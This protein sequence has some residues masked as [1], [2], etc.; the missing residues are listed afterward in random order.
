MLSVSEAIEVIKSK[1]SLIGCETIFV[2]KALGRIVASDLKSLTSH[3]PV[4]VSAMDGFAIRA[5][6]ID[7]LPITLKQVG[8]SQAGKSF[9]GK[10]EVGEAVRIFTGAPIPPNAD[11]VVVQEDV[12]ISPGE[13]SI[14][15]LVEIGSFIRPAGLDFKLGELLIP[16][17][18]ILTAR[19]VGLLASMNITT[20]NVRR[21]PKVG[22]IATGNELAMPGSALQNDQ[23]ISSNSLSIAGYVTV[24]GG[25]ATNIGLV[26]DDEDSIK[27]I[28]QS[29][30][31]FD[32]I[33]TVGG[34]SVG[35]F[36]L[37]QKVLGKDDWSP[38][39]SKLAMRPGKPSFFGIYRNIPLLGLPGNPVSAGVVSL[40]FLPELINALCG[41]GSFKTT[42]QSGLLGGALKNNNARQD[43]LRGTLATDSNNNKIVFPFDQQDSSM[44][45]TFTNADCL[46]IR[47]PFAAKLEIGD[48]I[49]FINLLDLK[50]NFLNF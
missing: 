5:A 24:F 6:D 28:L 17:G 45:S 35:E 12:D 19:D 48:P 34:A 38:G 1:V 8:V 7:Q 20:L 13:V 37:V 4:S 21:R 46:V 36:D 30:A 39:F 33:I 47:P 25:E 10:I 9:D 43:Y 32:L 3:P 29:A 15:S 16:E 14:K 11:S 27:G 40:I 26:E 42:V 22:I 50:N 44:M 2:D 23:I 41:L 31:G 18:K 49:N